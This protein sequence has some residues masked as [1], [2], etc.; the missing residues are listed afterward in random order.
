MEKML[1]AFKSTTTPAQE[2]DLF[3][4]PKDARRSWIDH[5]M[6]SNAVSEVSGGG[7][8]YL[9]LNNIVQYASQEMR[10]VL[11]AK[12]EDRRTD[13]L[14]QAEELT[15]FAQAWES[16]AVNKR[17][18][19]EVVSAIQERRFQD[20]RRCHICGEM[21]HL[22]AKCPKA[23]QREKNEADLTLAI[24]DVLSCDEQIWILDSGCSRHL[25]DRKPLQIGKRGYVILAVMALGEQK[26]VKLTNF[27]YAKGL[28]HNLISY[29][30]LDEK[31]Y[32]LTTYSGK[33]VLTSNDGKNVVLMSI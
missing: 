25:P 27:Y 15:H 9:V 29:E 20:T 5:L 21:G 13:Y 10:I 16:G 33:R 8:D 18:G 1:Q 24:P 17:I 3:T 11:M 19:R 6:Y 30:I 22:K 31:K 7:S 12:V 32:S 4:H 14:K 28:T 26:I 23:Y 2:M